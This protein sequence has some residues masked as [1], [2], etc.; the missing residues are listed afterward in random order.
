MTADDLSARIAEVG[1]ELAD[2]SGLEDICSALESGRLRS[3]STAPVRA[4][5]A[6][7]SP[8]AERL[9]WSLQQL[10]QSSTISGD[11]LAVVLRASVA[12]ANACR[13]QLTAT[14][15]VWTGPKV[16]G[17]FLRSTRV[18]IRELLRGASH[19]LVVI[20]YWIAARDDGDGIIEEI[21]VL[22]KEA[23]Y[24]GVRVTVIL[25]ERQRADARDNRLILVDAWPQGAPLPAILTWKLPATDQHLKLHAKVLVADGGDALVTSANLTSYA[26]DRNIEMGVRV[27]GPPAMAIS[28]HFRRLI[29]SGVLTPYDERPRL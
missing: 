3:D 2:I 13:R 27:K 29:T 20:G 17:S 16:E 7:G 8:I 18:V 19:D 28:D 22:L 26:M 1:L 10:W 14:Q 25:D 4:A 24:R 9:I 23:V 6:G 11:A 15:V 12:T 21:I 5:V